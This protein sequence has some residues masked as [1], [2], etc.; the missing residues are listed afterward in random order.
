MSKP[1]ETRLG[2]YAVIVDGSKMLLCRLSDT[3]PNQGK[4]TLPGGGLD[5]GETLEAALEREVLEET[6]LVVKGKE[7]LFHNSRFTEFEDR[8]Q[9]WFQFLFSVEVIGGELTHEI[10]GSTDLVE[11]V[12]MDTLNQGNAVDIV[13]FA[14][15][16]AK[17][18]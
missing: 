11:W 13:H 10:D 2:C 16:V 15:N 12:E 6:G 7:L 4:W 9:H 14:L 1:R 5:F 18:L 3:L 17:R 8:D